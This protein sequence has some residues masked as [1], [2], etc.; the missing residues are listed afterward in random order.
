[1]ILKL[2]LTTISSWMI[3]FHHVFITC[4]SSMHSKDM[5][6]NNKHDTTSWDHVVQLQ[7]SSHDIQEWQEK[8]QYEAQH[9]HTYIYAC[10]YSIY[11]LYFHNN[12]HLFT[13]IL[14]SIFIWISKLEQPSI[15]VPGS[16]HLSDTF[17]HWLGQYTLIEV[18]G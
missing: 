18:F 14:H 13:R 2:M 8:K 15:V 5:L 12:H 1:M 10:L 17:H 4:F 3:P 7:G 11:V 9:T 16:K 6:S